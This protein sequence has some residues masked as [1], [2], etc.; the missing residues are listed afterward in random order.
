MNTYPAQR[1]LVFAFKKEAASFLEKLKQAQKIKLTNST[2]YCGEYLGLPTV[3]V[4]TGCGEAAVYKATKEVL[5]IFSELTSVYNLGFVG[6]ISD[7]YDIEDVLQVGQV[8]TEEAELIEQKIMLHNTLPIVK[9]ITNS[10]PVE[11]IE[12]KLKI[13]DKCDVDI[14]DMEAAGFCRALINFEGS[15]SLIKI[16]SDLAENDFKD[17]V[18]KKSGILSEKLRKGFERALA[19]QV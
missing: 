19:S 2:T 12:Q 3:V 10:K 16:I 6:A 4:I 15:I 13:S 11:T 18:I 5:T 1:A 8:F 14:V 9:C 7:I 17:E